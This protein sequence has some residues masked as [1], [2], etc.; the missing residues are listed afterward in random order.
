MADLADIRRRT[1]ARIAQ[2][3]ARPKIPAKTF[4]THDGYASPGAARAAATSGVMPGTAI[5]AIRRPV[6]GRFVPVVVLRLDQVW[7]RER[8]E[9]RGLVVLDAAQQAAIIRAA[10]L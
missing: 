7:M 9:E 6:D 1:A 4:H 8:L 5:A 3:V 10:G 2:V